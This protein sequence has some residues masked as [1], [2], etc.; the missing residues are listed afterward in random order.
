[1]TKQEIKSIIAFIVIVIVL[2]F[3][4]A[5]ESVINYLVN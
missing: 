4:M 2:V 5:L 1:M 3:I